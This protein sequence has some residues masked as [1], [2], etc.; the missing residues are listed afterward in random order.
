MSPHNGALFLLTVGLGMGQVDLLMLLGFC[1]Y[2][3]FRDGTLYARGTDAGSDHLNE[4]NCCCCLL[5]FCILPVQDGLFFIAVLLPRSP[6]A[7]PHLS[8]GRPSHALGV[9]T[10][11][12]RG[13]PS[14][15]V[16]SFNQSLHGLILR[17]LWCL[18]L[19]P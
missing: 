8:S 15:L 6:W 9:Q 2:L 19:A 11:G 3:S 5:L 1:S 10:G 12:G 14:S 13:G 4:A 18:D 16:L 17:L 7:L